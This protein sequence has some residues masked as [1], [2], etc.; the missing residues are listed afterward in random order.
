[1][2]LEK[3]YQIVSFDIYFYTNIPNDLDLKSVLERWNLI[4]NNTI[5]IYEFKIAI[6]IILNSTFFKFN[7]QTNIQSAHRISSLSLQ[8]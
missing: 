6:S 4:C 1:M 8:F 3:D 2:P 5:P 7:L